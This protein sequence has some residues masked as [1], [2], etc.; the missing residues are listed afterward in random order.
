MHHLSLLP[1][2]AKRIGALLKLLIL[3][4]RWPSWPHN[5]GDDGEKGGGLKVQKMMKMDF[6]YSVVPFWSHTHYSDVYTIQIPTVH[7]IP[8]SLSPSP[9]PSSSECTVT[10]VMNGTRS[11]ATNKLLMRQH[12]WTELGRLQQTN[13]V[14]VPWSRVVPTGTRSR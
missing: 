3:A 4:R 8:P 12:S 6:I 9:S 7:Q 13:F 10:V 11:P 2:Y 14:A 5:D 1:F